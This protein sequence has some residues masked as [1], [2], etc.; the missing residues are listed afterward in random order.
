MKFNNLSVSRYNLQGITLIYEWHNHWTAGRITV[1][2]WPK[3]FKGE[4]IEGGL[5]YK[6]CFRR[7]SL[8]LILNTNKDGERRDK[9]QKLQQEMQEYFN[10]KKFENN[11]RLGNKKYTV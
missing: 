3:L 1:Y 6:I 4:T 10:T 8:T 7:R 5:S 11:K 9:Q 2:K